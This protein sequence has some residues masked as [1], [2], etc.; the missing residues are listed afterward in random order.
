MCKVT[1]KQLVCVDT[2]VGGVPDHR[3][4][5]ARAQ[6]IA[7]ISSLGAWR[8]VLVMDDED[9]EIRDQPVRL[10]EVEIH[11]NF[12]TPPADQPR[13]SSQPRRRPRGIR[14]L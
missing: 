11:R 5:S 6:P 4:V 3:D 9:V 14:S 1:R 8:N 2:V 13:G 12:M 7:S 10:T